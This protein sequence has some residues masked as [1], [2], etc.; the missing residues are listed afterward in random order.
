[1][2]KVSA[3]DVG[4]NQLAW[5]LSQDERVVCMEKTNI[6]YVTQED[7]GEWIDFSSIDVSF[8]SLRLILPPMMNVLKNGGEMV[9][10][11][12]PQ[13]EAGREQVG[14]GGVVRD[15]AVRL[16]VVQSI[17][18]FGESIGLE[19]LGYC[20]SPITGPAGNVEYTARWRKPLAQ[21]TP[22]Q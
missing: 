20:T 14:K 15:E 7:L 13:F 8:I 16:Q 11:I 19:W 22:E 21:N 10:L 3:I 6:R 1:M 9:T 18:E 12:K 5:N 2:K 17:R 4:T